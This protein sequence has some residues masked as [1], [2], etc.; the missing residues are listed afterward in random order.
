[1]TGW[2]DSCRGAVYPWQCDHIGHMNVMYYVGRFDEGTWNLFT[3]AGIT[4]AWMRDNQRGMAA[5]SQKIA[6]RRELHPGDVI[7]IRSGI[8]EV[9][10]KALRILHEMKNGATGEIAAVC[11]LVG[12]HLDT[13]TRRATPLPAEI[14]ERC[15]SMI[16]T[17]DTTGLWT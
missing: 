12:V 3:A 11:E 17:Y 15:R 7:A 13:T 8:L 16:V 5:I 1:M 14:A 10:D 4:S 9:K 6:Y 2:I